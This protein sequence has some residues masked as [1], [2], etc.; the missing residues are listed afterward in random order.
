VDYAAAHA[1]AP[2]DTALPC[3]AHRKSCCP[4]QAQAPSASA[5]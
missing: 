3:T 5:P 4:Y 1:P 2:V